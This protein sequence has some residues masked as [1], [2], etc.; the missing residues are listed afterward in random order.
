MSVKLVIV[1]MMKMD[2]MQEARRA[3]RLVQSIRSSTG[4]TDLGS[5]FYDLRTRK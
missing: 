2:V 4:T 3:I 5:V 1:D